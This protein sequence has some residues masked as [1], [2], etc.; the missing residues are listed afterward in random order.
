M[1]LFPEARNL[2]RLADGV[3]LVLRAAATDRESALD[4][5]RRLQEDG[6]RLLG[7]ILNDWY[8]EDNKERLYQRY[9]QYYL[10][11]DGK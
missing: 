8:P 6:T 9:Y 7:T 11:P 2:S 10:R 1:L 4:C 3:I 5:R